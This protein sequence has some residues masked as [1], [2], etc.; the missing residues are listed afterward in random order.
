ML[1]VLHTHLMM[2]VALMVG[3]LLRTIQLNSLA[4]HMKNYV[5]FCC[6]LQCL[7]GELAAGKLV[8]ELFADKVPRTAE[9]FRALCTG[10]KGIGPVTGKPLHYRVRLSLR[11]HCL[12]HPL[13]SKL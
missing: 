7:V 11:F 13:G 5:V 4:I 8:F 3:S 1:V 2:V 9:N 6:W 10:E 12:P